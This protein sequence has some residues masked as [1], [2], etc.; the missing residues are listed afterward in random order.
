M[1]PL[2]NTIFNTT[3]GDGHTYQLIVCDGSK[4]EG[5][6]DGAGVVQDKK[7]LVGVANQDLK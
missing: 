1:S 3:A 4:L 2:K 5:A 7:V 6:D